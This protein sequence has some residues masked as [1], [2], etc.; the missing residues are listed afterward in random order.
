M[1][2]AGHFIA[3]LPP[4]VVRELLFD[5]ADGFRRSAFA[6]QDH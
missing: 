2:E 4:E 3:W 6:D 5:F 1:T